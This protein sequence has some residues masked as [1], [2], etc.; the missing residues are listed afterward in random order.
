MIAGSVNLMRFS[1]ALALAGVV[2]RYDAVRH[3][4]VLEP[5]RPAEARCLHCGGTGFEEDA[6][7]EFCGGTG[8]DATVEPAGE[9]RRSVAD[10][11]VGLS[12]FNGL[13]RQERAYWLE[14]AR[15]ACP[16]DAWSCYKA[17]G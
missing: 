15:S 16:A 6:R 1:E 7:C 11:L 2:G 4:L 5:A 17:H 12:W 10:G 13:S 14:R 8:R 9:P 3:V